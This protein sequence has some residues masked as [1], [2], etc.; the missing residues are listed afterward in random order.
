MDIK[1]IIKGTMY[2]VFLLCAGLP[3]YLVYKIIFLSSEKCF[4]TI[5]QLISLLPGYAGYFTRQ[6]FYKLSINSGR[7]FDIGFG[8]TL[9]YSSV[10]IKNN[11]YIGSNCQI[12]KCTIRNGVKIGSNVD[13]VNRDTHEIAKDG[14]I[15]PTNIKKLKMVHIGNKTWIGNRS[16]IMAHVGERC[17][18]GA[19]SV[20]VKP[21]PNNSVAVGNPA[22]VIRENAN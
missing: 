8:S 19:G 7:N 22:K 11:V 15:L 20:V 17:I 12:A 5:S 1:K 16:I 3:L 4:E 10:K 9:V 6:A 21:I 14:T 13:I 2:F 18:I